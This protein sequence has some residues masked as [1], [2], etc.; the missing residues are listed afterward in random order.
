MLRVTISLMVVMGVWAAL[1]YFTIVDEL[2]DETDDLLEDYSV[3]IIQSFLAGE[4]MPIGGNGSNNTY[5]IRAIEPDSVAIA[6]RGARFSHEDIYIKYKAEYEPARVLRQ[7]FR[8]RDD[9]YFEITVATPTIDK[10][11]LIDALWKS[12][13]ILFSALL[14]VVLLI[15][16]FALRGGLRPLHKFLRWLDSSDVDSSTDAIAMD[17]NIKELKRLEEAIN[18]FAQR[19]KVAFEQQKEF[20]GNASHELQ[21]PIA[22]CQNRLE[23]LLD[24]DLTEAQ[25]NS[26]ADCLNTL[27][28]LSKLN[29]SLLMLSK[30]DNASRTAC[31]TWGRSYCRCARYRN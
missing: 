19:A 3:F 23:L 4:P 8:D 25:M 26:V 9:R 6:K 16:T 29:K 30:I 1:F 13:L 21:T 31:T 11:D 15:N 14:F 24:S 28:R 5:Y 20:I 7:V 17:G 22:I 27:S 10:S 2:H 12:L 18:G